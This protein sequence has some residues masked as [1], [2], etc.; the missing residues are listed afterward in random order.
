MD[1]R[2]AKNL[3]D[4]LSFS[5]GGLGCV[6]WNLAYMELSMVIC[7]LV[8]GFEWK[9]AFLGSDM[10]MVERFNCNPKELFVR[11]RVRDGVDWVG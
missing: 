5:L 9:L 1:A 2:E 10:E 11:S 3:K 6:G 7:A 4:M 8:L